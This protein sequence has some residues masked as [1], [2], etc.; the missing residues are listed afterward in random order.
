VLILCTSGNNKTLTI[1][2]LWRTGCLS[3][4]KTILELLFLSIPLD[5][6]LCVTD[7]P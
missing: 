3:P 7:N 5:R 6:N 1:L 2:F 4:L